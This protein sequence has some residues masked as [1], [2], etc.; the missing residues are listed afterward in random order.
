MRRTDRLFSGIVASDDSRRLSTSLG[1]MFG[2]AGMGSSAATVALPDIGADLGVSVGVATW[3]ISLYVLMLGVTTALYGR[4]SDLVG[5]RLPLFVGVAMLTGGA[6][7]SAA[8]Q[9]FEV[10]LGARI[11]QGAGAAA[12]PTLGAAVISARY[13]GDV[14]GLALG[15]LAGVAAAVTCLGPLAGGLIEHAWGWRAVMALP[16]LCACMLPFVWGALTR[17]GSGARLDLVG[18][19]LVTLA[20]A[21]L[22]LLV[23]SPSSG[24]VVA[25]VGLSLLVLS[26]PAVAAWVGRRPNG[27]LPVEVVGNPTVVR[28]SLAAAAVPAA[29]FAHLIAVPAVMVP[30]GWEPWEVGLLLVPSAAIAWVMPRTSGRLL[31]RLGP[32]RSLGL[33]ALTSSLALLVVAIGTQLVVPPLLV[34]AVVLVT[35][36]FGLGQP[37]LM[38]AVGDA[39]Q[40]DV[41]GVA[42]G[43]ATLIF[44]V[45]GSVGAAV[46]G[47][48]GEAVTIPVS[49]VVLAALPL[50]AVAVLAPDL[51]RPRPLM[52]R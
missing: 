35:V 27:F 40:A 8:A 52:A 4:V 31:A 16:V 20:A 6:V 44:L 1:L 13:E 43:I 34:A 24:R 17:Q 19:S 51:R 18:A 38:Q 41:R 47:G 39:V 25:L 32:S 22:A 50:V 30:R 5:V 49:L 36:A 23:Q 2:F 45:G 10:L 33:S 11:L 28:S 46:V 15:R 26:T 29:W 7:L 12:L 48:I 37:A 3:A 14:R 21:G 9:S 42:I